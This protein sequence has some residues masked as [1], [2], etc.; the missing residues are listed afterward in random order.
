MRDPEKECVFLCMEREKNCTPASKYKEIS[1]L[2]LC[3]LL[4]K[5]VF[6]EKFPYSFSPFE[7]ERTFYSRNTIGF[8]FRLI[9]LLSSHPRLCGMQNFFFLLSFPRQKFSTE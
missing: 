5:K 3:V 7:I 2:Y 8:S 6:R 1:N 4:K 9:V